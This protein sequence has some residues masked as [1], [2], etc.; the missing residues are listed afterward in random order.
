[1]WQYHIHTSNLWLKSWECKLYSFT[2]LYPAWQ[3]NIYTSYK[4][5]NPSLS[6]LPYRATPVHPYLSPF[7]VNAHTP[8]STYTHTHSQKTLIISMISLS[9]TNDWAEVHL[10]KAQ[11][12]IRT[13]E[14]L[15]WNFASCA[16]RIGA[17]I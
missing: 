1:M 3:T 15:K 14:A 13:K 10:P 11:W 5:F 7:H 17:Q 16:L 12:A 2:H 8:K 4:S 9:S 6:M